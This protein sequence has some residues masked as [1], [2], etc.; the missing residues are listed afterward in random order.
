MTV[1]LLRLCACMWEK[2]AIVGL[3]IREGGFVF[4]PPIA[5]CHFV[6]DTE[7]QQLSQ[8]SLVRVIIYDTL[9]LQYIQPNKKTP[10]EFKID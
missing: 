8:S 3:S 9:V 7:D 10:L 6:I 2:W 1:P 5:S 4:G